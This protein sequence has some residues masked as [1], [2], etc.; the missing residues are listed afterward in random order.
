MH[1][2]EINITEIANKQKSESEEIVSAKLN[3]LEKLVQFDTYEE[4][5]DNGQKV[6]S[7][8][9][10]ITNKNGPTKARLAVRGFEEKDLEIPR[11][12]PTVGK[13]AMRLLISIAVLKN[14]SLKTTDIKSAFLQGKELEREIYIKPPKESKTPQH[15][16]W[17][18][19]HG[20]Y[21][22]KDGARQ[23]YESVKEELMK[24]GFTQCKLNPA[25][26][27]VQKD[28]R[29]RGMICCHVDDFLHG[30]DEY[31]EL[32]MKKIRERFCAGKVE[33]K[34]FKYIGFKVKQFDNKVILDHSEYIDKMKTEILNPKRAS[35]K[36]ELLNAEEQTTYRQ[37]IGQLNWAVQGSRP[38]IAFEMIKMSTKLKQG[39]V[40]DLTRAS[41][42]ISRLKDIQS[43]MTFPRL[44]S[45]EDLKIVVFTDASL[46][47]INNGAGSTGAFIVWLMDNTGQCCPIAWNAHKI[48][49]VVRSTLAAETLSLEEGLEAG[50]YYREMLENIFG[51]EPRTIKIEAYVDNKSVIE[52]ILSTRL[53]DDKRLRV[54]IAAIKELIQLHDVNRIQW[55]PGHLQLANP[56]TKQ[57]AS[58]FNLLKVLQSGR[59]F[60]ELLE[61]SIE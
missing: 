18:L 11:D 44:T 9:W 30:G 3:E 58:G 26:F 35:A 47:N 46:G 50:F 31:F 24:L 28:S 61:P 20:L 36:H 8:R 45:L 39:K 55:V 52:A 33:K 22:L 6:L 7:T 32:L 16:I 25:A 53:V 23:F 14:W 51:L 48:K 12:S 42:K 38:D 41:K 27:Y 4:V 54:D 21:G 13:G 15:L 59:M 17:K 10:V 5:N 29:L 49:R 56:M 2:T 43:F 60:N 1:E 37:L 34:L 40:E 19:K 57:G